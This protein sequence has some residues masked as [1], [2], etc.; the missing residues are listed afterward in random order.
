FD[1]DVERLENARGETFLLTE[2]A[3]EDVLG[4]DVVVLE[5]AGLVLGEDDNLPGAFSEALEHCGSLLPVRTVE[6]KPNRTGRAR[7][8]RSR[9]PRRRSWRHGGS[10]SAGTSLLLCP[11]HRRQGAELDA[12]RRL[13]CPPKGRRRRHD[14]VAAACRLS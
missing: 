5:G 11:V 12:K 1:G 14:S 4:A 13:F 9:G 10:Q 2:E 3:E 6:P 7:A 8:D